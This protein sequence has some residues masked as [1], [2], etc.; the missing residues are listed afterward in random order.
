MVMVLMNKWVLDIIGV[1]TSF[2][3]RNLEE[4]IYMSLLEGLNFMEGF[5]SLNE[6]EDCVLLGK[7]LYR[8]V[9]AAR[10]FYKKLVEVLV[11]KLSF[12]E[13]LAEPC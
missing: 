7:S 1:E 12:N 8:I 3:H 4:E 13:Y 2:L 11:D 10:Q 5:E 9:Q 6:N